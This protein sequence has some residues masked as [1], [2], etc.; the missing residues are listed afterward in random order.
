MYQRNWNRPQR[1]DSC[2]GFGILLGVVAVGIG[3]YN[4]VLNKRNKSNI[5]K[6][7]ADKQKCIE[8]E[9]KKKEE[10]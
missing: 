10:W 6:L 9:V 7:L 1:K 2:L 5:E 3:S 4:V 8:V